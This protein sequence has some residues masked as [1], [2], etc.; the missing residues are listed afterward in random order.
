MLEEYREEVDFHCIIKFTNSQHAT[1]SADYMNEMFR[2]QYTC[3]IKTIIDNWSSLSMALYF[4]QN[5]FTVFQS[6]LAVFTMQLDVK[7]LFYNF[8]G[9]HP[10]C[11]LFGIVES[12]NSPLFQIMDSRHG[13][14]LYYLKLI[15]ILQILQYFKY[16]RVPACCPLSAPSWQQGH[17]IGDTCLY[18]T[19]YIIDSEKCR[20]NPLFVFINQWWRRLLGESAQHYTCTVWH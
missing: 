4:D 3:T 15:L 14:M 20:I 11:L 1:P 5:Y 19:L 6:I 10:N 12:C 9:K 13:Q 16:G 17:L 7:T 8:K 2:W 18:S